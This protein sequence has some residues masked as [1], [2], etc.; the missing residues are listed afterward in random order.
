MRRFDIDTIISALK[1]SYGKDFLDTITMQLHRAIGAQY[2]FIAKLDRDRQV[3]QTMS[4]VAGNDFGENFEYALAHT[5]CADVSHNTTCIYPTRI[6]QIYPNDQLLIDMGIDGYVGAPLHSSK[7]DVFGLVVAL[8]ASPIE[9]ANAVATLF[10]LFAGRIAAELERLEKEEALE[11]L[12]R[13]LEQKVAYRTQEL[14]HTIKQLQ[15]SQKQLVEQEKLASLGRLVAGVAH[16]VNTPLGVAMLGNSTVIDDLDKLNSKYA[17]GKLTKTDLARYLGDAREAC[18][19]VEFNLQRASELV[20]NFK[21]MASDFYSDPLV[22]IN[23]VDWVTSISISLKPMLKKAAI[24]LYLKLPETAVLVTTY[25]S[26]LAQVLTNLISNAVKHAFPSSFYV[27]DK[28][29]SLTLALSDEGYSIVIEDNGAGMNPDTRAKI[30][31][32]FFTTDRSTGS[33]GLGMSIVHNLVT[34]SLQGRMDIQSEEGKGT[35]ITL[36]FHSGHA[37][38]QVPESDDDVIEERFYSYAK[39][40]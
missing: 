25:P 20:V 38:K 13:S 40:V 3:S 14:E 9:D 7:G 32:P 1:S 35:R 22:N 18:R 12:H 37:E 23:L 30:L 34:G 26:R 4:L 16:E 11:Q 5:P 29:V 21:Q 39:R 36:V 19:A 27:A 31:D 28:C 15:A 8:Y 24:E 17:L 2:T 33:M 6:C 10:E